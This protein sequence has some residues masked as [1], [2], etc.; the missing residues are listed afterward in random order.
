MN[1]EPTQLVLVSAR[2]QV[3]V[4]ADQ[5]DKALDCLGHGEIFGVNGVEFVTV[6][7][8]ADFEPIKLPTITGFTAG[9]GS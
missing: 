1:V 3:V 9:D 7:H 6:Q 4:P 2:L 5:A 8:Q